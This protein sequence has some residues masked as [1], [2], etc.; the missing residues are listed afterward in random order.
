[1]GGKQY[2]TD[3][4]RQSIIHIKTGFLLLMVINVSILSGQD[5]KSPSL[6]FGHEIGADKKMIPYDDLIDYYYHLG[7]QS[8]RVRVSDVGKTTEG[9]PM[10]LVEIS[11]PVNILNLDKHKE[12]QKKLS[13]PRLISSEEEKSRLINESKIVVWINCQLHSTETAASQM[14]AELAYDLAT[15][16]TAEIN[17]ILKNVIVVLVPCANPDGQQKISEWY[18]RTLGEEWEGNSPPYLYHKYAGHDNNRDWYMLNLKETRIITDVLYNEWFPTIFWDL[19]QTRKNSFRFFLPPYGEPQNPNI[20]PLI[21]Y[22]AMMIG[23]AMT[24]EMKRRGMTGMITSAKYDNYWT[25][26]S[27]S[28]PFKHNIVGILTEAASVDL[29]TPLYFE[30][31][32]LVANWRGLPVYDITVNHPDPWPGGWWRLRD[33][34]N[35]EKAAAMGLLRLADRYHDMFQANYIIMGEDAIEQGKNQSPYAWIIP[36]GQKDPRSTYEMLDRML[37]TKVDIHI[38]EEPFVAD[39]ITYPDGTYI[40]YCSQPYRSYIMDLMENQEYPHRPMYLGTE[41][42]PPSAPN[43]TYVSAWTFPLQM[44]VKRILVENEFTCHARKLESIPFPQGSI[45]K[46]A[47]NN[48]YYIV[49]A[50]GNDDYRLINR[51]YNNNIEFGIYTGVTEIE[52]GNDNHAAGGS[53][54]IS[55]KDIS[56]GKLGTILKGLS[57]DIVFLEKLSRKISQ[58][59]IEAK[60]PRTAVYQP[61]LSCKDEGWTRY[62]LEDFE[63]NYQTLKDSDIIKGNLFDSFDCIILPSED[64]ESLRNG[65]PVGT[66]FPEYTGGLGERGTSALL[67][68]VQAGG[69]LVCID[70]SCNLAID[71]FDLTVRNVLSGDFEHKGVKNRLHTDRFF[72]PGSLLN[73]TIDTLHPLGF[74]M[75][76][77]FTGFFTSSQAFEVQDSRNIRVVSNYADNDLLESGWIRGEDLIKGKPAIVEINEGSG[78]ILLLGF[79]V[80]HRA[81]M[82]STFR[83]LFNAIQQSSF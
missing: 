47:G 83:I 78:K 27:R 71:M 17:S 24:T 10:L 59:V 41:D 39:G 74:G 77:E 70:E 29:A 55:S 56:A 36:P 69:T 12:D 19:H 64:M 38:A 51:L 81:Q 14:A 79:R 42:D 32:E 34:V 61:W 21:N 80:Q 7:K 48:G 6:F 35:Y 54:L 11:D 52:T 67:E 45:D 5:I 53:L 63:F 65:N 72:C 49:E 31:D 33:I 66:T 57:S 16:N 28:T 73:M 37:A 9:R 76:A 75:P 46:A 40:L 50:S 82:H 3:K 4:M 1:M 58:D 8:D 20:H 2:N 23:G 25:G 22:E 43:Q 68:F 18:A 44:G 15:G 26:H 60:L 62:V 30:R 13:D